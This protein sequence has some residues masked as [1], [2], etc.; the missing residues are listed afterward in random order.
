MR[1]C[2]RAFDKL[3]GEDVHEQRC[4][5]LSCSYIALIHHHLQ[6]PHRHS[7]PHLS[8]HL[9]IW[10]DIII[11]GAPLRVLTSSG[12]NRP[13]YTSYPYAV[14]WYHFNRKVAL[15]YNG[16]LHG[17]S[18]I[19]FTTLFIVL[20]QKSIHLCR[21]NTC[22]AHLPMSFIFQLTCTGSYVHGSA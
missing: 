6:P 16:Y 10:S 2:V 8:S 12:I 5:Y 1:A 17:T 21:S 7:H 13:C 9:A 22:Q 3:G 18:T 11:R 19:A 15:E 14:K 20:I 4:S